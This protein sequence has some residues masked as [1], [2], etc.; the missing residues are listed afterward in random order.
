MYDFF[1][2]V[3]GVALHYPFG[4]ANDLESPWHYP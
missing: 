2:T 4:G 1:E 3:F